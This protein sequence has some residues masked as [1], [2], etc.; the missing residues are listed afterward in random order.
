MTIPN[1]TKELYKV[2]PKEH[3]KLLKK[4]L[5]AERSLHYTMGVMHT[6]EL[7]KEI[8]E[9]NSDEIHMAIVVRDD[10]CDGCGG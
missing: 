3:L 8:I 4:A 7:L 1:E 10:Y 6:K 2:L 9:F 5:K